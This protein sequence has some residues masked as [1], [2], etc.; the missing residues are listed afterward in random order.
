M[1]AEWYREFY[2]KN[3]NIREITFSQIE[4]YIKIAEEKG[5]AWAQKA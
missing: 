1:T 5:I 2:E 3:D 4:K